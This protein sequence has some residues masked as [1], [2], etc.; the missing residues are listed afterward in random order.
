M[1]HSQNKVSDLQ[2]AHMWSLSQPCQ[3][4]NYLYCSFWAVYWA[5]H[6]WKTRYYKLIYSCKTDQIYTQ[7]SKSWALYPRDGSCIINTSVR[8]IKVFLSSEQETKKGRSTKYFLRKYYT[9]ETLASRINQESITVSTIKRLRKLL[10]SSLYMHKIGFEISNSSPLQVFP[11]D[12]H[13]YL[14]IS[15]FFQFLSF[16]LYSL[17]M[18][19]C[20]FS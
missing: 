13:L 17:C 12:M 11:V 2:Y 19:G 1:G 3:L 4:Y 20:H 5:I 16:F 15:F 10:A 18:A 6:L 7:P 8:L 9:Q 14:D